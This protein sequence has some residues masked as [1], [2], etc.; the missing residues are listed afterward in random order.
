MVTGRR[1]SPLNFERYVARHPVVGSLAA[2][3]VWGVFDAEGMLRTACRIDRESGCLLT[4]SGATVALTEPA[5]VGVAHPLQLSAADLAEWRR[6][7]GG[8]GCDQVVSQTNREIERVGEH[9][10]QTVCIGE[11]TG[12]KINAVTLR[13]RMDGLAWRRGVPQDAGLFYEY[14]LPFVSSQ[15]TAVVETSGQSVVAAYDFDEVEIKRVFFVAG[16]YEPTE[17]H[18]HQHGMPLGLV[19]DVAYGETLRALRQALRPARTEH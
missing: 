8:L 11:F 17:Y 9:E 3:L 10:A 18:V 16:H 2:T 6:W 4:L 15:I 14:S 12:R 1:W 19:D 13:R 5:V 7:A